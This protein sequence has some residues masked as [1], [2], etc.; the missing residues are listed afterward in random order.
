FAPPLPDSLLPVG[1][2]HHLGPDGVSFAD[3]ATVAIPYSEL[4]L[5]AT[6]AP[7]PTGIP[8]Y[9]FDT[10]L[11]NWERLR[12]TSFYRNFL[13]VRMESFCYLLFCR[14]KGSGIEEFGESVPPKDFSLS[15]GFP[16]PFNSSTILS[17]DLPRAC[18]VRLAIYNACGQLVRA[19]EAGPLPAGSHRL[20]WDGR[21][22]HGTELPSGLYVCQ[23]EA[24]PSGTGGQ[25]TIIL[26]GKV[27]LVR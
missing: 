2:T 4:D 8:V 18:S 23:I 26:R 21:D 10:R 9:R 13:F 11:G 1:P 12:V 14:A 7:G 25:A 16:N 15:P 22:D 5:A 3:S 6:G 17:L 24:R 20:Q 27:A 19:I